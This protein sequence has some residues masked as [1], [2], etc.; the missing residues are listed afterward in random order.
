MTRLLL[1]DD[2]Q[3]LLNSLQP[4]LEVSGYEV[5]IARTGDGALNQLETSPPD[6]MLLD[7]GL[8]DMDGKDVIS[9]ARASLNLPIIVLSARGSEQEKVEALDC[10]ANDYLAKPFGVNELLARVRAALRVVTPGTRVDRFERKNFVI[11]FQER[12]IRIGENMH[13]LSG[14]EVEL[15]R[16]LIN[17]RGRVVGHKEILSEI[18]GAKTDAD[19]QYVRVLVMQLRQK[20]CVDPARPK[21]LISEPGL[22]YRLA[23]PHDD[24]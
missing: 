22:G 6:L 15:L 12:K 5:T 14:R 13:R 8:P 10:G 16:V 18:W 9:R 3:T 2:E 7:L 21:F 17:A 23:L 11:D 1:V 4:V 20:I 19:S 24:W